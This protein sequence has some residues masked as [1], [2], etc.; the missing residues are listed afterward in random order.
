MEISNEVHKISFR[1]L[2]LLSNGICSE[3]SD[4]F[5]FMIKKEKVWRH[6]WIV[7]MMFHMQG[8][9]WPGVAAEWFKSLYTLP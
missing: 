4:E 3:F 9:V 7:F 5:V 8:M 2:Y 6:L 1:W